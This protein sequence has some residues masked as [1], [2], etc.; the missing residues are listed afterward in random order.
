[1]VFGVFDRIHD[2]H[3]Q[4]LK[5][6]KSLGDCLIVVVA[7][8]HIVKE[9]KGH[10]PYFN[11][12]ERLAHLKTENGIDKILIGDDKNG[13]WLVVKI[14]KPNIIALGYD[15]LALYENLKFHLKEESNHKPDI[16]MLS[17]Y[18]ADDLHSSILNKS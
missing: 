15:Q 7:Q 9:L 8:D 6:A 14:N 2:G 3:R 5:Q 10:K 11:L 16:V 1:M 17:A 4:M 18:R 13:T 12:D